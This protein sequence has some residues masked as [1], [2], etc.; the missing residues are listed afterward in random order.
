M[1]NVGTCLG[2]KTF[3]FL[4]VWGLS[5]GIFRHNFSIYIIGYQPRFGHGI[6]KILFLTKLFSNFWL[7][8]STVYLH[9]GM[10]KLVHWRGQNRGCGEQI[11]PPHSMVLKPC[12]YSQYLILKT[13]SFKFYNN[14]LFTENNFVTGA[15]TFLISF[16][17][18]THSNQP[19]QRMELWTPGLQDE[20]SNH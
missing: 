10:E 6:T 19:H 8:F 3:E 11:P 14:Y 17:K 9:W 18:T 1:E 4:S 13:S 12:M 7:I 20:C 2:R 5:F 16:S 15:Y